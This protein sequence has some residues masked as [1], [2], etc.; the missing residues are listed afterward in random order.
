MS[1]N[2]FLGDEKMIF[3]GKIFFSSRHYELSDLNKTYIQGRHS[4]DIDIGNGQKFEL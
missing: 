1:D 2:S 3:R 4:P